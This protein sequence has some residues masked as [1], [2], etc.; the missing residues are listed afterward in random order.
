MG[1]PEIHLIAGCN[2]IGPVSLLFG[3]LRSLVST[4]FVCGSA[5]EASHTYTQMGQS[6]CNTLS[7]HKTKTFRAYGCYTLAS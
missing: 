5:K 7:V 6:H 1:L 2:D 3:M 4:I